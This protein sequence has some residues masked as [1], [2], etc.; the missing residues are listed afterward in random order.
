[1]NSRE[2]MLSNWLSHLFPKQ[3]LS[4]Q[5]LSGDASF[6]RYF[7]C[8][9]PEGS[10]IIMDA[11]PEKENN[12]LPFTLISQGL[13]APNVNTPKIHHAN[14]DNGFLLLDD[15]GDITYGEAFKT[16]NPHAL[17][18]QAIDSLIQLQH[19]Q[20]IPEYELPYFDAEFMITE[21][22]L[23]DDWFIHQLLGLSL[24]HSEQKILNEAYELIIQSAISQPQVLI[25][26][27]YHS[28]NLMYTHHN[29]PGILDF[30]D[31][32]IG[33]ITYD[34]VS[35]LKDCYI[36]WPQN[37]VNAW[38]EYY[39]NQAKAANL[40][41]SHITE[42]QFFHAFDLMGLQRHF[43]VAGI[44]SRLHLRDNKSAYLKDIPRVLNYLLDTVNGYEEFEA[45]HWLLQTLILPKFLFP[46]SPSFRREMEPKIT[47]ESLSP[48][49]EIIP[50]KEF[51]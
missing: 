12:C 38:V 5:P 46:E 31:A 9:H 8:Y 51:S 47:V 16:Q 23:F 24:N 41:G 39:F 13:K 25:H 34:L 36:R 3:T 37:L 48:F 35:L 40:L 17:Y 1:M 14:Y 50:I 27:D 32:M 42:T 30:Q 45:L 19:S 21:L 49:P 15:F 20:N 7:R 6:R 33:P 43:K 44:F 26:R 10:Y 29:S 28:R 18:Q 4:L 2:T 11:P 22:E